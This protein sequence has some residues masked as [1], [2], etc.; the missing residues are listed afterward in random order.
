MGSKNRFTENIFSDKIL[1][2]FLLNHL[3][4]QNFQYQDFF[5]KFQDKNPDIIIGWSL[6]GQLATR[7][8][9][10]KIIPPNY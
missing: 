1:T 5:N 6:G 2:P 4:I 9:A 3:I 10:K 8:I 7:L